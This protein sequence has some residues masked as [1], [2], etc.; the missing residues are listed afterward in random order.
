VGYS[1]LRSLLLARNR[2]HSLQAVVALAPLPSLRELDLSHNA[3]RR[4]R[5]GAAWRRRRP[6][7]RSASA[8]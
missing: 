4:A 5:R 7:P 1:V 8:R 2:L 6:R 3:E